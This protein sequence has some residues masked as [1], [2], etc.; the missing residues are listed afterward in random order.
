MPHAAE[1][2]HFLLFYS[3]DE[4]FCGCTTSADEKF[5]VFV[6]FKYLVFSRATVNLHA[7]FFRIKRQLLSQLVDESLGVQIER[8]VQDHPFINNN[9]D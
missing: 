9:K 6:L 2:K 4:S 1:S 8:G 7:T 5:L 3:V